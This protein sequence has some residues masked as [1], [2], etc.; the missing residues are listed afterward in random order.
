MGCYLCYGTYPPWVTFVNTIFEPR[1]NKRCHFDQKPESA[2]KDAE[3]TFEVFQACFTIVCGP[4]KLC[5]TEAF[6]EVM[7][8]CMI[9]HTIFVEDEGDGV[10]HGL[11]FQN[12][13]DSN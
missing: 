7:I 9:M 1:G 4:A 6:R 12:V 3:K 10:C 2:K 11:D 5:D 13:A 8:A